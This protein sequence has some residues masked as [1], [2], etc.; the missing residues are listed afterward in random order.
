MQIKGYR[1]L[2]RGPAHKLACA[3]S[4][5]P[6]YSQ[7]QRHLCP[8]TH[9]HDVGRASALTLLS[10]THATASNA[11]RLINTAQFKSVL[12]AV[13][14]CAVVCCRTSLCLTDR[15][16]RWQEQ[17]GVQVV[18]TTSG[19]M[20]A[21]DGDDTLVYEPESTAAFILSEYMCW[22]MTIMSHNR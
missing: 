21:W 15:F 9:T 7:P 1:N 12:S 4:V 17:L 8:I 19:F 20:D 18:P 11:A 5:Q 2:R 22:I 16:D 6:V 14:C 13:V 10:S 3:L